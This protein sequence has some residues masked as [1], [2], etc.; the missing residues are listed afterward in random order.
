MTATPPTF[1]PSP[2]GVEERVRRGVAV[3]LLGLLA[4]IGRPLFWIVATRLYGAAIAGQFA[5]AVAVLEILRQLTSS[6][7]ADAIVRHG[8]MHA[9]R[10]DEE[11]LYRAVGTALALVLVVGA[12]PIVG[13]WAVGADRVAA[14]LRTPSLAGWATVLVWSVPITAMAEALIAGTRARLEM[15]WHALILGAL[16]PLAQAGLAL[17]LFAG[18]LGPAAL[19]AAWVGGA[20]LALVAAVGAFARHYDL[21]RTAAGMS[22]RPVDRSVIAFA[23]PQSANLTAN[24]FAASIDVLMLGLLGVPAAAIGLYN[25]GI[26]ISRGLRSLSVAFGQS[27]APVVARFSADGRAAELEGIYRRLSAAALT[28]VLPVVVAVALLRA[29]LLS[30]FDPAFGADT[31]FVLPLLAVPVLACAFGL[32][33][34]L[35]AMSGHNR[36]NL[37][38]SIAAATLNVLLNLWLIPRLGLAGAAAA[39]L[40]ATTV[41]STMAVW[42]ATRVLGVRPAPAPLMR[43]LGAFA[44][45]LAAGSLVTSLLPS[46]AGS[47]AATGVALALYAAL[48]GV[49]RLRAAVSTRVSSPGG[50][51]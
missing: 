12:V 7:L 38:N 17:L 36:L 46:L 4:R 31:L 22:L 37:A 40:L 39:T 10:G 9:E 42:Q 27:L 16:L 33:G 30:L 26:Q 21:G 6:G 35:V 48:V 1:G 13:V 44:V 47:V 49:A 45:A 18:G 41:G 8:A 20:S 2:H 28:L 15:R 3:N 29:P 14:L 50:E 5:V 43:P 51:R 34:T 32:A 24:H 11:R 19:A 25:A 23:V